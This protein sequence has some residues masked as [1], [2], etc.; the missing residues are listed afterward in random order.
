[1]SFTNKSELQRWIEDYGE[2]SDF[3]RSRIKGEFPRVGTDQFISP[4]AVDEAMARE[5]TPSPHDPRVLGVDIARF[6]SDESVLF[7]R[8][9]MDARSIAP[10][11][12]RGL[13]LDELE[14]RIVAVCNLHGIQEIFCDGGG[15]GGGVVDHLRRRGYLV[16][17][18]QFGARSD[19][20]IDNV[21]FAN[22]RAEIWG[23]LR[24]SLRYLCLPNNQT[25]REQLCGPQYSFSRTSDA[26]LLEPKDAMKRRGL[27]SPDWGDALAVTFGAPLA[28]L[29]ALADW[30]QPQGAVHEYNPFSDSAMRGEPYPESRP[31]Y[32]A[33]GYPL[34]PEWGGLDNPADWANPD[35]G[36]GEWQ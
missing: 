11:S 6:G 12:F 36:P 27:P 25:L 31:R 16:H 28:T 19:Q 30:A 14:D 20:A 18:I 15:M 10:M 4:A 26:I 22:K 13:P 32:T 33:P 23:A 8:Q 2:D 24:S 5:L 35:A 3:V 17:D 34:K 9:G 29:P 21:R 7:V 1:V